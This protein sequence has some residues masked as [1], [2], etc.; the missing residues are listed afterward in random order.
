LTLALR[1]RAKLNLDLEVLRRAEDGFHDLRTTM[2]AIDLH[3]VLEI[4]HAQETTLVISGLTTTNG[5]DNLVLKAH[6]AL[7]QAARTRLPTHFHLHKRI[8]PGSGMGGASSDAAAALQG[9]ASLH[10]LDVDLAAIALQTGSDVPFFL[11]GGTARAEG[12]GEKL[13][14]LPTPDAWFAIAWPGIELSTAAVYR[15][16]D[17][18]QGE[19]PNH[20]RRAAEHV[21]PRL[22]EFARGLVG[23]EWQMTGSGSA[24]FL[25]CDSDEAARRVTKEL[26]GWTAVARAVGPWA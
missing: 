8:P 3:D 24:F 18:M 17:Q 23:G 11:T 5:A 15:A 2:Q 6:S 1:A 9:L 13:T 14:R 25:R 4:G 21:E 19:P 26:D 16:W 7:E 20:L 12:R 10:R 22:Q